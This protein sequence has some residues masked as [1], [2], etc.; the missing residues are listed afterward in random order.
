MNRILDIIACLILLV[1]IVGVLIILVIELGLLMTVSII[2]FTLV[3]TWALTRII[4]MMV[5][6]LY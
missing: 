2:A 6:W 4:G 5:E 1:F 3:C